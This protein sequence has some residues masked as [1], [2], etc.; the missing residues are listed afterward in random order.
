M[1]CG[2]GLPWASAYWLCTARRCHAT[3]VISELQANAVPLAGACDS[4]VIM[5]Q[6]MLGHFNGVFHTCSGGHD[7]I[8]C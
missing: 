4:S 7:G 6:P 1:M 2:D 3:A 5:A 8:A